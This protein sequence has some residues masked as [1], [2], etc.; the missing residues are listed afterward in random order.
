[1]VMYPNRIIIYNK[2][3]DK[4]ICLIYPLDRTP[5]GLEQKALFVKHFLLRTPYRNLANQF[6]ASFLKRDICLNL[7]FVS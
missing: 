6:C 4:N 7:E 1:M 5:V 3:N 2:Y